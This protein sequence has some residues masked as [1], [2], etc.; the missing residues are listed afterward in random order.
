MFFTFL[1][2]DDVHYMDLSLIIQYPPQDVLFLL[3]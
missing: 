2:K 1:H 3:L